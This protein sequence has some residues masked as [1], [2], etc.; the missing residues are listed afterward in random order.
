MLQYISEHIRECHARAAQA[1]RCAA[2]TSDP[3]RKTD[4]QLAEQSWRRLADS[5]ATSQQL[6]S[7]LV[8]W[9]SNLANRGEWRP[10]DAAP[11]DRDLEIAVIRGATPHAVAFPCRRILRGWMKAK[12]REHLKV[13]P[14]HWRAWR[15]DPVDA[16]TDAL[17]HAMQNMP[18]TQR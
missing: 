4:Y 14:T 6:E 9:V 2:E 7:H 18:Q 3:E 5:Y 11:F 15:I 1:R 13:R 12:T 16:A 17:S 8:D 10:V